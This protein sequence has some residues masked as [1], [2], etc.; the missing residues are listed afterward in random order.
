MLTELYLKKDDDLM[1]IVKPHFDS[2][3]RR[4]NLLFWILPDQIN[5]YRRYKNIVIINIT[6]K[7]NQFDMMLMLIIV[8]DNNF[9]N[10]IAAAA[11]LK[12]ETE[13]TF[14]WIL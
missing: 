9:R 8:I 10:I 13:V 5:A 1:W 11:I 14:T 4:L 7:T 12:D 3:E 6:S 2:E